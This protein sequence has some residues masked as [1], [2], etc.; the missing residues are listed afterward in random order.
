MGAIKTHVYVPEIPEY[1]VDDS[2]PFPDSNAAVEILRNEVRQE[3]TEVANNPQQGF[4][5]HT[6]R[7]LANIVAYPESWFEHVPER[8]LESFAGTGNPFNL[9]EIQPGEHV[10]D[11]GSGA[12]FDC[13]IAGNFVGPSGHVIG[14]DM[15]PE[16]LQKARKSVQELGWTHVEFREGYSEHLPVEDGWADVVISNGVINLSSHKPTVFQ[17]IYRVLKPGGRIQIGDI[18][19]QREVPE[20]AKGDI[21]LW[22]G[23]VAGALPEAELEA[24]V[25]NAGFQDFQV[26]WKADIF[27]GAPQQTSAAKERISFLG[28]Q[29]V[30]Y[31]ARKPK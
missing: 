29:G 6:G 10:V 3:Y 7:P 14:V 19:L 5:F 11:I 30:N 17:E 9:G 8:A 23:C 22:R 20:S 21:D 31:R 1:E 12:G 26:T 15:T 25:T 27:D 28:A 13:L 18:I 16:M 2:L 24:V 4:H